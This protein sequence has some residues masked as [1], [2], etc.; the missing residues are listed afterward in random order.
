MKLEAE[1]S[2][3]KDIEIFDHAVARGMM[4]RRRAF[5]FL[6][7]IKDDI[8]RSS[9][10]SVTDGMRTSGAGRRV[11]QWLCS[12]KQ[13]RD[14]T[15]AYNDGFMRLLTQFMLAEGLEDQIWLWLER[16]R[17][18]SSSASD[19]PP[20]TPAVLV[21]SLVRAK[22]YEAVT[23][24]GAYAS[25]LRA[26]ELFDSQPQDNNLLKSWTTLSWQS[27]VRAWR[28]SPASDELFEDYVAISDQFTQPLPGHRAH[29]D[30]HHPNPAKTTPERAVRFF[31]EKDHRRA[32]KKELSDRGADHNFMY[33]VTQLMS[34]GL[35]TVKHLSEAG[36]SDLAQR[37]L[38]I[39]HQEIEPLFPASN[40][41]L[42]SAAP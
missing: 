23:L 7:K 18:M 13:E 10:F 36:D 33:S 9:S 4:T 14:M 11:A 8:R 39:L 34:L 26:G 19:K 20:P 41:L 27:T 42:K 21:S 1:A 37:I 40:R 22:A 3:S 12:S 25:I 6:I 16:I 38:S 15:F 28:Y 31:T 5:G 2:L 35:D 24:D 17:E 29:L 32:W 30:L